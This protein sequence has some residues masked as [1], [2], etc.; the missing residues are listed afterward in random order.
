MPFVDRDRAGNVVGIYANPQSEE[1]EWVE[2]AELWTP[3]AAVPQSVSRF[4]A[5]AALHLAGLLDEV[6]A[7]MDDPAT[8]KLAKLAWQDAQDFRRISP[9][10]LGMGA[11]LGWSD[12]QL[13][14]LFIT[15]A[16]IEA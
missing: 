10:V 2:R 13:D 9:T 7:L 12:A 15:A 5:R 3:P 14:Q 1:H 4:Q 11:A 6:Q 8:D 16:G